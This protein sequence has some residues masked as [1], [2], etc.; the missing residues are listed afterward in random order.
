LVFLIKPRSLSRTFLEL[1]LAFKSH[2]TA[3][4]IIKVL[5]EDEGSILSNLGNSS[6]LV[7]RYWETNYHGLIAN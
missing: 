5:A 6:L 2:S 3:L 4:E 1:L 7:N